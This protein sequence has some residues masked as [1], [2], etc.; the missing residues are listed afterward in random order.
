MNIYLAIWSDFTRRHIGIKEDMNLNMYLAES[1][2][3]IVIIPLTT[4]ITKK[5]AAQEAKADVA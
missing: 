3:E 4:W 1:G 5:V 2:Y